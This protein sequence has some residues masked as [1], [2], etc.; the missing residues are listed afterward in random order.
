[1]IKN[2][3]YLD[4]D[5]MY[6]LSSQ[7]FDGITEYLVNTSKNKEQKKNLKLGETKVFADIL[8]NDYKTEE[9]KYLHDYS[10]TLFEKHLIEKD[11]VVD[12]NKLD[13]NDFI[14]NI[15]AKSFVKITGKVV[16]NDVAHL[17]NMVKNFNDLGKALV[18]SQSLDNPN[19]TSKNIVKLAKEQNLNFDKDFLNSIKYLLDFG[20]EN[21]FE[22]QLQYN[23]YLFSTQIKREYLREKESLLVKKYARK[24]EKEFT[25]FGI[26][27]QSSDSSN[28]ENNIKYKEEHMKIALM[29]LVSKFKDVELT[30]TGKLKNEIMIDPIAIYTEL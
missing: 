4:E 3:I 9:K 12:I 24:T 28:S 20:F 26:I 15:N 14:K 29:D 23:T 25:I 19:I 8:K 7:L 1:M 18:F 30:F 10:Y 27:T 21:Q 13:N 11:K 5:K 17:A 22:I 6:S 2:F 16:F